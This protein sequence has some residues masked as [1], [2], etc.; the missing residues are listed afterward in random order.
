MSS[1]AMYSAVD[2]QMPNL[3]A[4]GVCL[5]VGYIEQLPPK[6]NWREEFRND[7]L[8]AAGRAVGRMALRGFA[9][10]KNK[11]RELTRP[12][13]RPSTPR[14]AGTL[15]L[16]TTIRSNGTGGRHRAPSTD[17]Q[18][19]RQFA[20]LD[21]PTWHH[22]SATQ[23]PMLA[24]PTAGSGRHAYADMPAAADRITPVFIELSELQ[25]V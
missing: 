1:I 24:Q 13:K 12:P 8:V 21:A 5:D 3:T 2:V 6:I 20:S 14:H 10:V 25:T 15:A 7:E 16:T 9:A 19:D 11:L 17:W 23:Y 4:P 18:A 22:A